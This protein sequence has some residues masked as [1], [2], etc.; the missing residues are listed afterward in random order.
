MQT[1]R[2]AN[3][4][5]HCYGPNP[6]FG[7]AIEERHEAALPALADSLLASEPFCW[8]L[9]EDLMP[10][11]IETRHAELI[12]VFPKAVRTMTSCETW[13]NGIP[14]FR[15]IAELGGVF[16]GKSDFITLHPYTYWPRR[17]LYVIRRL[18]LLPDRALFT[19]ILCRG[20]T[21]R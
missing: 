9:K 12:D 5:S 2:L 4:S 7:K 16:R 10:D 15:G 11:E 21:L 8:L 19:W 6:K 13:T 1:Q 18:S 17:D 14:V 20:L 3:S